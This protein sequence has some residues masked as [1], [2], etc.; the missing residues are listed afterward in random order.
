[1]RRTVPGG[2]RAG[3]AGV[4]PVLPSWMAYYECNDCR[5]PGSAMKT[6]SARAE[7]EP[8]SR[9]SLW[10]LVRKRPGCFALT[11]VGVLAVCSYVIWGIVI[12]YFGA[13][14]SSFVL[15]NDGAI[16]SV[17]EYA[18]A[19]QEDDS[20]RSEL[21]AKAEKQLVL[22]GIP[23]ASVQLVKGNIVVK[24]FAMGADPSE[25]MG[26]SLMDITSS[27]RRSSCCLIRYWGKWVVEWAVVLQDD[28]SGRWVV[29]VLE[30]H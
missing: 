8:S 25:S 5:A 1:M 2:M 21:K 27:R 14:P 28:S 9:Y 7:A 10:R 19:L 11:S 12:I 13:T 30:A 24:E 22:H 26:I 4:R 20:S 29:K 16:R 18:V 15:R 23:Y 6:S 17:M 3:L